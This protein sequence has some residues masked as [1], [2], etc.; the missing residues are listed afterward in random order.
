MHTGVDIGAYADANIY[1]IDSG[2]VIYNS[3]NNGYGY[4][5]VIGHGNIDENGNYEYYSAYAHQIRL[6]TYI[7]VGS[8]VEA[9]QLIGNVGSTGTSTGNHLHF[10]I[11]RIINGVKQYENPLSYFENIN[12]I[13]NLVADYDSQSSCENR[14]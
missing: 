4:Y 3:Y 14:N 9:G 8:V 11:Y 1:A 7:S 6:S 5:T 12:L 13:G 2:T 10:E